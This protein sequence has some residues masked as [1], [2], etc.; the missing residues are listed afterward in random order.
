MI[1]GIKSDFS[2]Y[3]EAR[4]MQGPE[5]HEEKLLL[6]RIAE[7]DETAFAQLFDTYHHALGA[8]IY[9]LT[10]SKELSEEIT[11]DVFLK[12][13][14]TREALAE[15][16]DFKAYLF[17]VSR[18]AA[19]T[20]LRKVIRERTHQ[21]TWKKEQ[22]PGVPDDAQEKEKYLS[23]VDEAINQLSPQRKKI[24]LLS[25]EQG[26]KYEEIANRMG[27][28]RF[29]VRAHIQ[30]AVASIIEYLK[31]RIHN[32]LALIWVILTFLKK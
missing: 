2:E 16:R 20:A 25:R 5:Q 23:L 19:I 22:V 30:Q 3:Y 14:M 15:V 13:W 28:S 6:D 12:I 8:F 29:T 31:P 21:E 32:E 26:L 10:K 7:G 4:V 1:L 27:I 18:N 24:Y 11:L 9:G 17:T